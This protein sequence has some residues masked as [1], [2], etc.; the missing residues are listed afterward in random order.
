[1]SLF[2]LPLLA[3]LFALPLAACNAT[4]G[5]LAANEPAH[6]SKVQVSMAPNVGSE[7]FAQALRAKTE[8][9]AARFGTAGA[10]K[11]LRIVVNRHSYKNAAMSLLVGDANYAGGRVAVVDV[12][13]GRA[14]G[15][16]DVSM[17]DT[18][19]INGIAGAII[20]ASQ[21]KQQV[22]ER[23]AEGL[24]RAALRNAYG[25]AA[26][27]PVLNREEPEVQAPAAA[28][29]P[30]HPAQKPTPAAKPAPVPVAAKPQDKTAMAMV[31]TPMVR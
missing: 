12:A 14:Q 4:T 8:Q 17:I 27:D 23:L 3:A 24:A 2:R 10:A 5:I 13:S 20:A 18:L 11:E 15:E 9:H 1:M 6:I 25:S 16:A 30:A 26:A 28:P 21:D 29:A 31:P 7:R 19:A 22:D